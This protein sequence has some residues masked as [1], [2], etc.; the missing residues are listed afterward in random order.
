VLLLTL[1]AGALTI[2]GCSASHKPTPQD[3]ALQRAD[4]V[5]VNRRLAGME[6]SLDREVA[7]TKRAWP[8]VLGGLPANISAGTRA[9]VGAADEGAGAVALPALFQERKSDSLTGPA[10]ELAGS[11][12]SSTTLA[13]RGWKLIGAAI[14]QAEHGSPAA[15]DFARANVALYI[16]TEYDAHFALA[17]TGKQLLKSYAKLGGPLAFGSSLTQAEVNALANAYS[18]ANFRLEP[19]AGVKLGS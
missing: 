17:Q 19:H 3:L 5:A 9:A 16:E 12:R 11:I 4:F 15:R 2:V 13:G 18:D 6:P 7:A 8:L 1:G 14:E 10:S